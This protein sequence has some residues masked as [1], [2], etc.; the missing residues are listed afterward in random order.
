M[1]ND[2]GSIGVLWLVGC[3]CGQKCGGR[4]RGSQPSTCLLVRACDCNPAC[5]THS[6]A[7]LYISVQLIGNAVACQQMRHLPAPHSHK[8]AGQEALGN[9]QRLQRESN[10]QLAGWP[11]TECPLAVSSPDA[12]A[13]RL[14]VKCRF[15]QHL[16]RACQC[17]VMA[18]HQDA[19]AALG[20]TSGSGGRDGH[21]SRCARQRPIEAVG[22]LQQLL[23]SQGMAQALWCQPSGGSKGQQREGHQ[24]QQRRPSRRR[25]GARGELGPDGA[26]GLPIELV[27]LGCRSAAPWMPAAVWE[28]CATIGG[29]AVQ[30]ARRCACIV[31]LMPPFDRPRV[32][33]LPP[34][35][36]TSL[37]QS[38]LH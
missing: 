8:A 29:E 2:A 36:P 17:Q 37:I 15:I 3:S 7:C 38:S 20:A 6:G 11:G 4:Q 14:Q 23:H 26:A 31:R 28:S 9:G 33:P 27:L 19:K 32:S 10:G 22:S 18:E 13:L 16:G 25:R 12:V 35:P 34:P 1:S 21:T 5:V 30:K 24:E